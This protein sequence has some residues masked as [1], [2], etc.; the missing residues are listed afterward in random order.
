MNANSDIKPKPKMIT[1]H[2]MGTKVRYLVKSEQTDA[3][4]LLICNGLGQSIEI[5]FPLMEELKGRSIIAFDVPG[6]GRSAVNSAIRTIPDYAG[7]TLEL[8][9][10]I[11]IQCFDILGISWGGAVAQ[12]MAFDA[13]ERV[14]KLVLAITSAGGI[15]SWWGTPIAL[16]EVMFPLRFIS[17]SYGNFIGPLMYGGETALNPSLFKQYSKHAIKPSPEG[18]FTQVRA[19]CRWT[20]LPWLSSLK[21][22]TLILAGQFDG[23]I[24][25]VN[26]ILL[27]QKIHNARL[28]VFPADHL[29]MYT[30]RREAGALVRSFLT[31]HH[32]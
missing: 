20:S 18:Y 13:P 7:F 30:R 28:H 1:T 24:P 10:Q 21:Q 5:L 23:L 3:P 27:A 9:S 19:M 29:L 6:I 26:Q 32:R 4:P 17:K 2:V 12:Q 15:G 11:G 25:I 22:P 16:S 8:M 31:D 14:G